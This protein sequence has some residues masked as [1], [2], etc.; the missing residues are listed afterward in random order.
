MLFTARFQGNSS[1]RI[2]PGKA[3]RTGITKAAAVGRARQR[4]HAYRIYQA[5][6]FRASLRFRWVRAHQLTPQG[7][8]RSTRR[9]SI[10]YGRAC[11]LYFLVGH[12][13]NRS[14]RRRDEA[15]CWSD[16][17]FG[18]LGFLAFTIASLYAFGHSSSPGITRIRPGPGHCGLVGLT[19]KR[20]VYADTWE[21][22]A[23]PG[24]PEQGPGYRIPIARDA[25]RATMINEI[26]DCSIVSTLAHRERTGVSDGENAVLVL[27]AMNR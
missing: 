1:Q 25:R 14:H 4:A 16:G 5:P 22:P 12:G 7:T 3:V 15:C 6:A 8:C 18:L 21:I 13:N 17:V 23:I 11:P 19:P 2:D 24:R 10:R 20:G 9:L 27:K 26:A